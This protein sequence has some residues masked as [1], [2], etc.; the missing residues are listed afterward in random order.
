M[1]VQYFDF[2]SN[3]GAGTSTFMSISDGLALAFFCRNM[4][5]TRPV[6]EVLDGK[7]FIWLAFQI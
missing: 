4:E 1:E 2:K 5:E 7:V 6:R 3:V